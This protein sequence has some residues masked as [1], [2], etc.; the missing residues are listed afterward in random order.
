MARVVLT[1]VGPSR[2]QVSLDGVTVGHVHKGTTYSERKIPGRRYVASRREITRWFAEGPPFAP[3][4]ETRKLA[5]MDLLQFVLG[6]DSGAYSKAQK[7]VNES[8]AIRLG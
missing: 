3:P 8:M 2:Y 6:D 4:Q 5:V 7:L 1:K